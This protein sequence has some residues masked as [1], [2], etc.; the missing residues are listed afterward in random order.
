MWA[1]HH[2][3]LIINIIYNQFHKWMICYISK[4]HLHAYFA[5]TFFKACFLF[6]FACVF[7]FDH[8][9][10]G[11]WVFFHMLLWWLVDMIWRIGN[12][13]KAARMVMSSRMYLCT[14]FSYVLHISEFGHIYLSIRLIVNIG[15]L[16][17]FLAVLSSP[18][19]IITDPL[20]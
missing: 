6:A 9:K 13:T 1:F 17:M 15:N 20:L 5:V 8:I 10:Y 18:K 11:N 2:L 3:L 14:P 4:N 7:S 19:L 12:M 16:N